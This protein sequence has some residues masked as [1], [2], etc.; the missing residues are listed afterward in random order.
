MLELITWSNNN[1]TENTYRVLITA[2]I[3]VAVELLQHT[4]AKESDKKAL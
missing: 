1:T 2:L 3:S 4:L